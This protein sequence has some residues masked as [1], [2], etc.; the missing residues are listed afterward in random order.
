MHGSY[1]SP[2]R[3]NQ[4]HR[5]IRCPRDHFHLCLAYVP[6]ATAVGDSLKFFFKALVLVLLS[7]KLK[8][9]SRHTEPPHFAVSGW[10]TTWNRMTVR[11]SIR[12]AQIPISR[13][14]VKGMRNAQQNIQKKNVDPI[15]RP[16]NTPRYPA[17][18]IIIFFIQFSPLCLNRQKADSCTSPFRHMLVYTHSSF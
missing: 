1:L 5:F 18:A 9:L 8:T 10:Y 11:I 7:E 16:V 14:H 17:I 6:T 3:L 15:K 4:A 12:A 2:Q 13:L